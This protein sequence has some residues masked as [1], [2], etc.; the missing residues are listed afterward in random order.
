MRIGRTQ[1][2]VIVGS[3]QNATGMRI[4]RT[5]EVVN[6]GSQQ[7]ATGESFGTDQCIPQECILGD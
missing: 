4:G 7:N 3:Q 6:V 1:E 5:Q 2:A